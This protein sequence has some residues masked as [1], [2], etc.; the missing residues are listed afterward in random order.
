MYLIKFVIFYHLLEFVDLF[1]LMLYTVILNKDF[2]SNAIF[3]IIVLRYIILKKRDMIGIS[4]FI[5]FI[6]LLNWL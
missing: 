4:M 3:F 6:K 5:I 1:F 2:A